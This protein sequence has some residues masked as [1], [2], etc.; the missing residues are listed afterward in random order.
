LDFFKKLF[1]NSNNNSET[2]KNK[3]T[4]ELIREL[5]LKKE[6][7]GK[8][9]KE[10][11]IINFKREKIKGLLFSL[12]LLPLAFI[13]AIIS[14]EGTLS[15]FFS[16][17]FVGL[18]LALTPY[19]WSV[20]KLN[21][22]ISKMEEEYLLFLRDLYSNSSS[23][24]SLNQAI[25]ILSEKDYGHLTP[26]IKKLDVWISWAV[27]FPKAFNKFTELLG[28]SNF[29]KKANNIILE[30]YRIG[31][32]ILGIL[33]TLSENLYLIK[34]LEEEK[35]SALMGQAFTMGFI[36]FILVVVLMIL[37]GVL[38]PI[39]AQIK[40][41]GS[42]KVS[43]E[44]TKAS[45]FKSLFASIIY[46]QAIVVGLMIGIILN[47]TFKAGMKYALIFFIVGF[48]TNTF[49]ISTASVKLD[50]LVYTDFANPGDPVDF[51]LTAYVD[52]KPYTGPIY[53]IIKDSDGKELVKQK[54]PMTSGVL[55]SSIKIPENV[56]GEYVT[57]YAKLIYDGK[58]YK[59]NEA[60]IMTVR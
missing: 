46:I 29:I 12:F 47:G 15:S 20:I 14:S 2:K 22:I 13:F 40:I 8:A 51:S 18:I 57:L 41:S 5:E 16:N 48:L 33:K 38:I 26:Y 55:D 23:G 4:V 10:Y 9:K 43:G 36:F 52:G 54:F 50:L 28:H 49:F 6:K 53:L 60:H 59:S 34:K 45:F 35:R 39:L 42:L 3:T 21:N 25:S 7:E 17:L 19:F 24:L 1:N 31:G 30:S 37:K 27:P 58:E 44:I 32:D 56:K 11:Q